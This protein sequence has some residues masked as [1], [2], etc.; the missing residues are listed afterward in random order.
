MDYK[1]VI[2]PA[3]IILV[4]VQLFV[5]ASMIFQQEDIVKNGKAFKFKTAPI[6]PYD[7]FRGKYVSLRYADVDIEV[8]NIEDWERHEKVFVSLAED[9]N[10]FATINSISKEIPNTG[11][12]YLAV[13]IRRL[14]RNKVFVDYPFD[15]FYMEESKAYEAE[16][17]ARDTR[18]D[19]SQVAYA[20]VR[21]KNGNAVLENVMINDISLKEAVEN[22][23]AISK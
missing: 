10:G 16:I 20:L 9:A 1:K 6:D 18:R 23:R 21:I 17:L 19:T 4:L 14:S 5:P 12:E 15:R 22:E 13:K 3:F 11:S 7:P 8:E 2:F